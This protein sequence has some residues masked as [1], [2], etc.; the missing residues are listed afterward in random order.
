ME[1]SEAQWNEMVNKV[2]GFETKIE[3]LKSQNAALTTKS[4]ELETKN[5]EYAVKLA[6]WQIKLNDQQCTLDSLA[7][8]PEEGTGSKPPIGSTSGH[9]S[10]RFDAQKGEYI[11][12]EKN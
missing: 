12:D 11:W 9:K 10:V 4:S 7:K 3:E 1:I 5:N 6:E 8:K 2:N